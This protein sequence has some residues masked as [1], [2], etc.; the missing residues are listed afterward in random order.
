M[1]AGFQASCDHEKR[2]ID[3]SE[4]WKASGERANTS[5]DFHQTKV[6]DGRR[7]AGALDLHYYWLEYYQ[8]RKEHRVDMLLPFQI[9]PLSF[10]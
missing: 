4:L 5:E 7:A 3:S 1:E 10:G 8:R 6:T 2:E 9:Y